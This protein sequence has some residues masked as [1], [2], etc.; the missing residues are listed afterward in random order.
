M[1]TS[2]CRTASGCRHPM[3]WVVARSL[4]AGLDQLSEGAAAMTDGV[5]LGLAHLGGGALLTAPLP[6]GLEAGIVA[7]PAAAARR[8]DDAAIDRAVHQLEV[9]V[10]PGQR[11]HAMEG[12]GAGYIGVGH[13]AFAELVLDAAHA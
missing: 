6:K 5:L 13:L 7:V 9:L 1:G 11:Q 8:P 4:E 2:I 12:G 10:G 3:D